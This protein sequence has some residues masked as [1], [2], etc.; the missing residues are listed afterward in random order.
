MVDHSIAHKH[1]RCL[2]S[3]TKFFA[4]EL[5]CPQ[6]TNVKAFALGWFGMEATCYIM[7]NRIATPWTDVIVPLVWLISA[8][9]VCLEGFGIVRRIYYHYEVFFASSC[10]GIPLYPN[11]ESHIHASH[12]HVN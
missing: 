11:P 7:R 1:S 3:L 6:F 9:T 2:W 10:S 4:R 8:V 5:V 12:S